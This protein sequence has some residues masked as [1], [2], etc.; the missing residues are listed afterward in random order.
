VTADG[1][2]FLLCA[3]CVLAGV[4]IGVVG[5]AAKEDDA[6]APNAPYDPRWEAV[7]PPRLGLRCWRAGRAYYCEP[8]PTA[9]FGASP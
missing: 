3:V 9:T 6:P 2:F 7:V 8:D 1:S 5:V 4:A